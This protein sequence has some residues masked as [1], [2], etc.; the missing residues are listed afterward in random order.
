MPQEIE[1]SYRYADLSAY[2]FKQKF[3]I[4]LADWTF[5]SLIKLI[6]KTIKYET[7]GAE[8][9]QKIERANKIPVYATWH[10]RI[11]PVGLL[12]PKSRHRRFD[13]AEFRRRIYR[14]IYSTLRLRYGARLVNARRCRCAGRNDSPD[15]E[16]FA[17][18]FYG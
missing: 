16:R 17:D 6:G 4:H 10:N 11:F 14:A 3:S 9:L 18:V 13:F 5:Y 8:N 15:A 2:T 12:S 1:N 7:E